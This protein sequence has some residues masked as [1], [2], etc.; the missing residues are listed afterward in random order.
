MVCQ[1]LSLAVWG[2]PVRVGIESLLSSISAFSTD[3]KSIQTPHSLFRDFG[4]DKTFTT[5]CSGARVQVLVQVRA[6]AFHLKITPEGYSRR[7]TKVLT[8]K[9]M[10]K[11]M[12]QCSGTAWAGRTGKAESA[13][14]AVGSDRRPWGKPSTTLVILSTRV[15]KVLKGLWAVTSH[16][17]QIFSSCELTSLMDFARTCHKTKQRS[18]LRSI[19]RYIFRYDISTYDAVTGFHY[20]ILLEL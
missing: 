2:L 13:A 15:K 7:Q 19:F 8:T 17:L 3:L 6:P 20:Y 16:W 9:S 18:S 12:G 10:I 11:R 14:V 4:A 1:L 5:R